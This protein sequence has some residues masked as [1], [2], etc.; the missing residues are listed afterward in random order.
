MKYVCIIDRQIDRQI[1]RSGVITALTITNAG[2]TGYFNT[3]T[4]TITSEITGTTSIVGGSGYT[5]ATFNLGI[6]GG[7]GNGCTG[8][9]QLLVICFHQ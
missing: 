1:D 2:G 4:I 6:S 3:P 7:S 5:N 9:L 8:T